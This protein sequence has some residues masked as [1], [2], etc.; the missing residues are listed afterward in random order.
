MYVQHVFILQASALLSCCVVTDSSLS[1]MFRANI[2][3]PSSRAKQSKYHENMFVVERSLGLRIRSPEMF[4]PHQLTAK[5]MSWQQV[6]FINF[7][8]NGVHPCSK[9]LQQYISYTY[10]IKI[11]KHKDLIMIFTTFTEE[12][13]EKY[14]IGTQ[15]IQTTRQ[16]SL[17]GVSLLRN[18]VLKNHRKIYFIDF[19]IKS[20]TAQNNVNLDTGHGTRNALW[21]YHE[22]YGG[23][24]G[25]CEMFIFRS[26]V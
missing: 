22:N 15:K 24:T 2:S 25:G 7:N 16:V 19:A 26:S 23:G 20:I 8:I 6:L 12:D 5:Q 21:Y 11:M 9:V 13:C 18:L 1:T 10:K 17:A 3:F 4:R 14:W